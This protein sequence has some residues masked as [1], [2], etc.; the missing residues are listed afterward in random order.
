MD[1]YFD[2]SHFQAVVFPKSIYNTGDY[3]TQTG[4]F[5]APLKAV[6][7]FHIDIM[8]YGVGYEG[9]SIRV[10]KGST[11]LGYVGT[12]WDSTGRSHQRGSGTI[13]TSLT[14]G[15]EILLDAYYKRGSAYRLEGRPER[16][17]AYFT[18]HPIHMFV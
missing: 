12:G 3:N 14:K 8:E 5:T 17:Y 15:E 16:G 18:G 2:Y 7:I 9:I 4:V 1:T 10:R 11:T 6:Y 13:I